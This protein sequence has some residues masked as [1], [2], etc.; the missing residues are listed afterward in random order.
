MLAGRAKIRSGDVDVNEGGR[1]RVHVESEQARQ[2][3][4]MVIA[5]DRRSGVSGS[6]PRCSYPTP[7]APQ[8]E[9]EPAPGRNPPEVRHCDLTEEVALQPGRSHT[10]RAGRRRTTPS[11][12]P[13]QGCRPTPSAPSTPSSPQGQGRRAAGALRGPRRGLT[14]GGPGD[15]QTDSPAADCLTPTPIWH[16]QA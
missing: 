10:N 1:R 13:S 7:G 3:G 11:T 14:L 2:S 4:R 15:S 6:I 16:T 5:R 9:P 12:S 8:P